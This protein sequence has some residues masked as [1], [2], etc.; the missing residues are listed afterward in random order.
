MIRFSSESWIRIK[1]QIR[2]NFHDIII[3]SVSDSHL[4]FVRIPDPNLDPGSRFNKNINRLLRLGTVGTGL[5]HFLNKE[6]RCIF[7]PRYGYLRNKIK[8]H[9]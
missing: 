1:M 5:V 4:N 7:L 6:G 8:N 3:R 2:K 9:F